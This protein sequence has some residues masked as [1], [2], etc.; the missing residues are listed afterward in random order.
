M[1]KKN[2]TIN[3]SKSY[4]DTL[5]YSW[6]FLWDYRKNIYLAK[7]GVVMIGSIILSKSQRDNGYEI[8]TTD[9]MAVDPLLVI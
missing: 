6:R 8:M 3:L 9:Y 1:I 4:K 2:D 5:K 7:L